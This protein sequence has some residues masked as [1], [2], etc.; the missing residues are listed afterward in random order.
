MK[1]LLDKKI[2]KNTITAFLI[3]AT[4]IGTKI[5]FYTPTDKQ[6]TKQMIK[7]DF[8]ETI[9]VSG[10]YYK[11]Y[12]DTEK[13][14]IIANYKKAID[15]LNTANN[16]KESAN[17]MMWNKRQSLLDSQNDLNYQRDND[18]NPAT[19]EE[20]TELEI[21]QIESAKVISEMDYRLAEKTYLNSEISVSS[22]NA[23]LEVAKIAY[24]EMME[25]LPN[26]TI[27]VNEI[28]IQHLTI[29]QKVEVTFDAYTDQVYKGQIQTI[30]NVGITSNGQTTYEVKVQPE[31]V[32]EK[33]MPNM[34]VIVKIK[35]EYAQNTYFLPYSAII[36]ENSQNYVYKKVNDK[37]EK[38]LVKLGK[39]GFNQVEI[40]NG[41]NND[42]FI[43]LLPQ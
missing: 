35:L 37:N 27:N 7:T 13:A 29:G 22:A 16:Q 32:P 2:I 14:N 42:D 8:F 12:S 26:I 4:I 40:T 1:K 5:Y 18:T 6:L 39:R 15:G 43:I 21:Q 30:D 9:E 10:V 19:K 24:Q 28:Y 31:S 38:I 25:S 17:V 33:A 34:N 23:T 3:I 41:I 11:S 20:Y 36:Y